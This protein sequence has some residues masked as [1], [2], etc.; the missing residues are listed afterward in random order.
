[1]VCDASRGAKL[2][3]TGS[4]PYLGVIGRV[5]WNVHYYGVLSALIL[6]VSDPTLLSTIQ[7]EVPNKH[8]RQNKH[9]G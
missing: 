5:L 6:M 8:S 1:M 7:R 9:I 4:G 3:E 2:P